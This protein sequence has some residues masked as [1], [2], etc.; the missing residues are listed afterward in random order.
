[1]PNAERPLR[2]VPP[3]VVVE[4]SGERRPAKCPLCGLLLAGLPTLWAQLPTDPPDL[5]RSVHARCFHDYKKMVEEWGSAE[6]VVY[7]RI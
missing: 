7:P 5:R 6:P 4:G 2:I 1:M 3:P